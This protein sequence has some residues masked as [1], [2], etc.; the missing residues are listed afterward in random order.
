MK[1]TIIYLAGVLAAAFSGV[2]CN[3]LEKPPG[4]DLTEDIVFST[5]LNL[6]EFINGTYYL[7]VT[8]DAGFMGGVIS[9]GGGGYSA[10][11]DEGKIWMDW[12]F[13]NDWNKGSLNSNT[14]ADRT[15]TRFSQRWKAIRRANIL[16]ERIEGIEFTPTN[17]GYD[18]KGRVKGEALWIRA[19]NHYELLRKFGGTPKV[20]RRLNMGDELKI[21]RSS[22]KDIVDF[23]VRDCD[24][25]AALLPSSYPDNE[26]GRIHKGAA[27]ILKA[28]TLLYAASPQFNTDR[29]YMSLGGDNQLICYGD[30]D[31]ERWKLAADAALDV[32]TWAETESGWC[33]LI[34]TGDPTKDYLTTWNEYDN[35]EIILAAKPV[36][37]SGAGH[38]PYE[39]MTPRRCGGMGGISVPLQFVQ[40]YQKKD[41]T[42]QDWDFVNGGDDLMAKYA[43]L[44]PRFAQTMAYHTTAWNSYRPKLD[45]TLGGYDNT[46]E[47]RCWGGVFAHK[48]VPYSV[49]EGEPHRIPNITLFRLAEAYLIY[50]E[51]LNEYTGG[52]AP[53][54]AREKINVIRKRAGMP[55]F[56]AGMT[57][58]AFRN[59]VKRERAV[60]LAYE[61]HRLWDLRRWL[62]AE[63]D[64]VMS[65][66]MYGINIY[67]IEGNPDEFSY[68]PYIFEK[69]SFPKRMYLN[70][71]PQAEVNK[72]YII[73]NPG[74]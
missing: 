44:D 31:P 2:S 73:Q 24:D 66:A 63:K 47:F 21:P 43:Q 4:V 34:D 25:A 68:E 71:W 52:T 50:A 45:L 62:D 10:A 69:R 40:L 17:S 30:F 3:Y 37:P 56:P 61:N 29:P 32:I 74:Y 49:V 42:D 5:E 19:Y 15:D 48:P 58:E 39:P 53:E 18:Y 64:G 70:P 12:F 59:A 36:G 9:D 26:R 16:I 6:E 60:E 22:I 7:G 35:A 41:G 33:R 51:A 23:I 28:R 38:I 8:A 54:A 65:G 14:G 13:Q 72:G 67:A 11:C 20:D 57:Q 27:L 55:D 46:N 1:R